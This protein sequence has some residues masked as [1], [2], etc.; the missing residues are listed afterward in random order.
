M[1]KAKIEQAKMGDIGGIIELH[2]SCFSQAWKNTNRQFD[3]CF[4]GTAL[5]KPLKKRLSWLFE[6]EGM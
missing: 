1:K 5:R 3:E 4:S 2:K 6:G